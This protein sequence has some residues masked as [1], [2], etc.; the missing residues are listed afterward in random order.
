MRAG[1]WSA[2]AHATRIFRFTSGEQTMTDA[3]HAAL[4]ILNAILSAAHHAAVTIP[5]ITC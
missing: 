1:A 5:P 2:Y 3:V 4:S